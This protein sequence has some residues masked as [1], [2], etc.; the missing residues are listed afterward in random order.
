VVLDEPALGTEYSLGGSPAPDLHPR[1]Q[2][3]RNAI[4]RSDRAEDYESVDC[5]CGARLGDRLLSEVDR[6]GIPCRN[7][8]CLACGLIRVSPRWRQERYDRFYQSEYRAL[9]NPSLSSKTDYAREIAANPATVE[10]ARWIERAAARHGL[11]AQPQLL[12][13]GA[14]AGWNLARL[15]TSWGRVGYDVDEEYL[16]I[17][18]A[19]FGVEMRRGM[20]EDALEAVSRADIVLLSHVVE[21]FPMPEAMLWKIRQRLRPGALLLVEVPGLFRLHRSNLDPRSYLQNAHTFTFCAATLGDSC[22]RAGLEVLEID[23][24]AR[25]VCRAGSPTP[26]R[27]SR[28]ALADRIIRYL[29]RCDSGY[30]NYVRLRRLP[31]LGRHAAALWKRTYFAALGL[32]VSKAVR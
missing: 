2:E 15:P 5:P 31:V 25:A 13:L 6:H 7:L 20:V 27:D 26:V 9:Y 23:Q 17:G 4:L 19:S 21:H 30:R 22:R 18:R 3:A 1:Q 8:I 16:E 28:A 24:V 12:E 14:G 29:R 32:M 10:R 11:P